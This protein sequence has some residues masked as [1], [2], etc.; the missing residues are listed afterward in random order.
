[1]IWCWGWDG[2]LFCTRSR[3]LGS[4]WR[5]ACGVASRRSQRLGFEMGDE[6]DKPADGFAG[7]LRSRQ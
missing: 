2:E 6:S 5:A 1:M 3:P 7:A 4:P